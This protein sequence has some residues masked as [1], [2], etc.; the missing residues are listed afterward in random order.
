MGTDG[1]VYSGPTMQPPSKTAAS[2]ARPA[3]RPL[4]A[5]PWQARP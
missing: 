3:T 1:F 4:M 5:G 2:P